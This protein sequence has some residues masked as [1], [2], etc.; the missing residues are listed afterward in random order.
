[1]ARDVGSHNPAIRGII[2]VSAADMGVD[3]IETIPAAYRDRAIA[4]IAKSFAAEGM[5][6][7]AGCT[8]KSLAKEAI[9][10]AD[11]WNVPHLAPALADWP[12]LV[13]T[14]DAGL[15]ASNNAFVAALPSSAA[16]VTGLHLATDHSHSGKR[17]AL[18]TA[19]LNWLDTLSPR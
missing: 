18:A 6:P 19:I 17:V 16:K 13:T 2:L 14:S 4:T 10:N 12:L 1:M 3:R 15:A 8:P 9:A 5:A 11:T 7:L